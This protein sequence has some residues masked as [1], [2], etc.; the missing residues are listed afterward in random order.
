MSS[1]NS[2]L[3]VRMAALNTNILQVTSCEDRG[4]EKDVIA[5]PARA[6][7]LREW[8]A[9]DRTYLLAVSQGFGCEFLS[10]GAALGLA[11]ECG[12]EGALRHKLRAT[13]GASS[14]AKVAALAASADVSLEHSA[15]VILSRAGLEAVGLVHEHNFGNGNKGHTS[16]VTG[17]KVTRRSE[18]GEKKLRCGR[19]WWRPSPWPRSLA[20]SR[21]AA[22]ALQLRRRQAPRPRPPR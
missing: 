11:D 16:I 10:L 15:R 4:A 18:F 22:V 6:P 5:S 2:G 12:G 19:G 7:R 8:H 17:T 3:R 9:R 20:P 21:G 14:G 1:L 13:S